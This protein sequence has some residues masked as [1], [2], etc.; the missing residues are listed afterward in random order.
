MPTDLR[1][2]SLL[3][4]VD[5]RLHTLVV[6]TVGLHQVNDI[7]AVGFIG[8]RVADFEEIPLCVAVS[9][10]V[11]LKVQIVLTISDFNCPSEVARFKSG[12]EN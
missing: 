3:S 9:S 12:F 10:V 8:S 6:V 5:E 7:E 11:I 1:G 2:L 4:A